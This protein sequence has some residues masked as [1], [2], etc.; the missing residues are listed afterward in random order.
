MREEEYA[1][2]HV[3]EVVLHNETYGINM[4]AVNVI[5]GMLIFVFMCVALWFSYQMTSYVL[6]G[7]KELKPNEY[8]P[9]FVAFLTASVGLVGALR[10]QYV[11]RKREIENAH[12]D[13]K[14]KIYF[15]FIKLVERLML[16][17]KSEVDLEPLTNS[18]LVT[19]MIEFKSECLLW[20]SEEVLQALVKFQST[21][22]TNPTPKVVLRSI[23]P[24]YRAMRNDIGLKNSGLGKD[25]FAKWPLSDPSEF[26]RL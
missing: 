22:A 8:V 19:K 21:S 11:I 15:S 14:T 2:Q 7:A 6:I 4:K 20:G 9:L 3:K 13:K 1:K 23:D 16:A 12:R 26:D 18:E 25:F 5:I 24:L 17:Q 10:T